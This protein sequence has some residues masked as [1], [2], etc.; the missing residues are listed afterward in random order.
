MIIVKIFDYEGNEVGRKT[1][2]PPKEASEI[3]VALSK[4]GYEGELLNARDVSLIGGD[5]VDGKEEYRMVL[6]APTSP[7]VHCL[8]Q[9]WSGRVYALLSWN[10]S[11]VVPTA[12]LY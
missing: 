6:L 1:Y 4:V 12:P 9:P 3:L 10:S 2:Y 8:W 7:G 5:Q 11:F